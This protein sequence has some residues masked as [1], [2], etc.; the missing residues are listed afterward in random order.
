[1]IASASELFAAC[2]YLARRFSWERRLRPNL[3]RK[4]HSE[5]SQL[6]RLP[7]EEP[8]ALFYAFSRSFDLMAED[9]TVI[10]IVLAT[11]QAKRLGYSLNAGVPELV[12]LKREVSA[13]LLS[14]EAVRR[15]FVERLVLPPH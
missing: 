5:A 12:D 11:N 6:A 14:F 7:Q 10:P 1:L 15:W 8:A 2:E 4:I 3:I 9:Y 13:G